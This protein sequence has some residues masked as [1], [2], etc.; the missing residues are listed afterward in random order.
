M[1]KNIWD[2]LVNKS[3][4]SAEDLI[5]H[6][7]QKGRDVV[8][9]IE[10]LNGGLPSCTAL[11]I[12]T[13]QLITLD[14][15]EP[16]RLLHA[17]FSLLHATGYLEGLRSR[18]LNETRVRRSRRVAAARGG[19]ETPERQAA[20]PPVGR[21]T[22]RPTHLV[23]RTPNNGDDNGEGGAAGRGRGDQ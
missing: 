9:E 14:A 6:I 13:T 1:A 19:N 23:K 20:P 4:R 22:F 15:D 8:R 18:Q 10:Q 16:Q 3:G 17:Y 7:R 21:C 11:T 5:E 12:F 2:S